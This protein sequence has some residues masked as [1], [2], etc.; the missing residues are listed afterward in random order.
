MANVRSTPDRKPGKKPDE[1]LIKKRLADA[2]PAYHELIKK[3]GS[4]RQE[5]KF[6]GDKIGWQLKIAKKEKA[7]LYLTPLDGA[8]R[9]GLALREPERDALLSSSLNRQLREELRSAKRV[10]EG[11]PLRF[12]VFGAAD[13]KPVDLII[14]LLMKMRQ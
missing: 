10:S 5:W 8:F 11:Y 4:Y 1:L 7:L 6:Y 12:S 13:M 9:I 3:T 2:F 14:D